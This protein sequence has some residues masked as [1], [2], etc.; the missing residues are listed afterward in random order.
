MFAFRSIATTVVMVAASLASASAF[1]HP[2]L[3]VSSPVDNATVSAP[4]TINLSFTEKLLPSLS[5]AELTMTKMPGMEMPPMKVAAK[6]APS[7]DGKSLIVTPDKPLSTGT[8]RL[9]WRVVSND[10]HP[11]KG[12]ISFSV[13]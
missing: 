11:V 10:T 8:Y 3:V 7:A 1:A 4:A 12:S 2:K 6:A 5:G 9:H 13:K